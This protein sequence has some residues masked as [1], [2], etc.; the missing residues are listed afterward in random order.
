[1]GDDA[2]TKELEDQLESER[3]MLVKQTQENLRLQEKLKDAMD[4][5]DC[6]DDSDIFD[7]NCADCNFYSYSK[8]ELHEGKTHDGF[9]IET[10]MCDWH[11]DYMALWAS[12]EIEAGNLK[13][14]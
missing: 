10:K 1:M 12:C 2:Y 4:L 7:P 3:A 9:D 14:T 5:L 6:T 8:K 11:K 13:T